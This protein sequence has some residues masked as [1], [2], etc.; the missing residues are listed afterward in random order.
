[1][2]GI[3]TV[4]EQRPNPDR[5]L[6]TAHFSRSCIGYVLSGKITQ[7]KIANKKNTG[8]KPRIYLTIDSIIQDSMENKKPLIIDKGQVFKKYSAKGLHAGH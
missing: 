2:T 6:T 8:S 1:M 5:S 7:N 3:A 4:K